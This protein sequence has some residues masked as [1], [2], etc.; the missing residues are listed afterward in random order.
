MPIDNG[1]ALQTAPQMLLALHGSIAV[2]VSNEVVLRF[3]CCKSSCII[4]PMSLDRSTADCTRVD[5]ELPIELKHWQSVY[6]G[7]NLCSP[8]SLGASGASMRPDHYN[9]NQACDGY[10]T[11]HHSGSQ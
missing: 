8:N 2:Q 11:R 5:E 3:C 6:I 9:A 10:M 7:G 1:Q 4:I